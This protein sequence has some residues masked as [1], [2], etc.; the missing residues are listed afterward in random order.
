MLTNAR[1]AFVADQ[2]CERRG[3]QRAGRARLEELLIVR[4]LDANLVAAGPDFPGRRPTFSLF[5]TIRINER[6]TGSRALTHQ[7]PRVKMALRPS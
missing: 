5:A 4:K 1:Q 7:T 3:K 2:P 6:S